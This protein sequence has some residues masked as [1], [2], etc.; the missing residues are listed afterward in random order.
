MICHVQSR[1]LRSHLLCRSEYWTNARTSLLQSAGKVANKWNKFYW[2]IW[3]YMILI[4][5]CQDWSLEECNNLFAR[6]EALENKWIDNKMFK[7]KLKN[8]VAMVSLSLHHVPFSLPNAC[9]STT[10]LPNEVEAFSV[11]LK[12]QQKCIMLNL[13]SVNE[14]FIGNGDNTLCCN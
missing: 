4:G 8:M 6:W 10:L 14:L 2:L 7:A 5:D 9:R 3:W 12:Q 13:L 1:P 11:T